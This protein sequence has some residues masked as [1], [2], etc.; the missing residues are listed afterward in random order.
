MAVTSGG[1]G[2]RRKDRSS[3]GQGVETLLHEVPMPEDMQGIMASL[4]SGIGASEPAAPEGAISN[5][6]SGLPEQMP[7]M[8]E[9][10]RRILQMLAQQFGGSR[11]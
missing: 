9:N 1:G 7:E 8:D 10:R 11:Q 6:V 4:A 2:R 3:I 5:L